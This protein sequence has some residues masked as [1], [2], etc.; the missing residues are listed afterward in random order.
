MHCCWEYGTTGIGYNTTIQVV[1]VYT[2]WLQPLLQ[3]QNTIVQWMATTNSWPS[4]KNPNLTTFKPATYTKQSVNTFQTWWRLQW[5]WPSHFHGSIH[6]YGERN[7]RRCLVMYLESVE[8]LWPTLKKNTVGLPYCTAWW[9]LE[10]GVETTRRNT[11]YHLMKHLSNWAK[12]GIKM[13][14]PERS[15]PSGQKVHYKQYQWLRSN[16]TAS[17]SKKMLLTEVNYSL[18]LHNLNL[19]RSGLKLVCTNKSPVLMFRFTHKY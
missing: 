18:S 9:W 5:A 12:P 16:T 19:C 7:P 4:W 1:Q 10:V 11:Q 2:L 14:K 6:H 3:F 15:W 8:R 17:K 13:A